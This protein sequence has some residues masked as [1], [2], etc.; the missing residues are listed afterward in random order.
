MDPDLNHI[1]QIVRLGRKALPD[2]IITSRLKK[3]IMKE[4]I[5]SEEMKNFV[6]TTIKLIGVA[7]FFWFVLQRI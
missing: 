2:S 1:T 3:V 5:Q 7:G 4:L 6:F